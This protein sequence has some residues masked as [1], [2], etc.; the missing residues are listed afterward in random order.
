MASITSL[1]IKTN[2][3]WK[4]G[5]VR[6]DLLRD[7]PRGEFSSILDGLGGDRA[8]AIAGPRRSG[9]TTLLFH[10]IDYLLWAGM[11]PK[12]I[13]YANGGEPA[14]A[15]ASS[16]TPADVV[17]AYEE[18]VLGERAVESGQ[19]TFI[20]IDELHRLKG[21]REWLQG[22]ARASAGSSARHIV[23]LPSHGMAPIGPATASAAAM[24]E[25]T[26]VA[27]AMAAAAAGAGAGGRA[28]G[29]AGG[30]AGGK[31]GRG[32]PEID[33]VQVG[34]LAFREFARLC[35]ARE[36]A[37]VGPASPL[38]GPD[39]AEAAAQAMPALLGVLGEL[40]KDPVFDGPV[41]YVA[42]LAELQGELR[43]AAPGPICLRANT[44]SP[45]AT[46]ST[47]RPAPCRNG[48]PASSM[49]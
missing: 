7:A 42:R 16:A 19:P 17:Q 11:D 38:A 35:G 30:K 28:G 29:R 45:A 32:A 8:I 33:C 4:T 40:P 25:A 39:V 2:C 31:A 43:E 36:A 44:C 26:T 34:P 5:A 9:K 18:G 41:A 14:L 23:S 27:A 13:L 49:A 10:T 21:W 3:F 20:F 24:A 47:S 12:R 6:S 37:A 15:A 22:V 1:L 46:R 48:R